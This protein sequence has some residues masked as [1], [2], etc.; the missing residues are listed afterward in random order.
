M[1]AEPLHDGHEGRVDRGAE[2]DVYECL[3]EWANAV[4]PD[5]FVLLART[6]AS[7]LAYHGS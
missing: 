3:S 4:E 6:R 1:E 7:L 5:N 2:S